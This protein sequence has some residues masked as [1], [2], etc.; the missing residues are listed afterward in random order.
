MDFLQVKS[1]IQ[2]YKVGKDF[3]DFMG[4]LSTSWSK[5]LHTLAKDTVNIW[6]HVSLDS[7]ILILKELKTVLVIRRY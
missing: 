4:N 1:T 7:A 5:W 3:M 6:V 2:D